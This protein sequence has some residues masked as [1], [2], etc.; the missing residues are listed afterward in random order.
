V[1]RVAGLSWLRTRR[2]RVRVSWAHAAV[3]IS[4]ARRCS[5]FSGCNRR[6][7]STSPLAVP[8]RPPVSVWAWR[9][10]RRHDSLDT[11]T[12]PATDKQFPPLGT[13]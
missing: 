13:R 12:F 11:P 9:T 1:P 7:R 5:R 2:K 3:K 8:N 4:F 10:H 6:I